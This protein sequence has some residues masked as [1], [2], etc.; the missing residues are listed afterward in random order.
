MFERS[1][2]RGLSDEALTSA[3]TAETQAEAAAAARRLALI[4]E[5]TA[6]WCDDEDDASALKLIDGWAHAKAQVGAACNLGPH[7]A[8]TQ[9]RIGV[10]LRERL[11]R[12]AAV[13]GTG[14][15]SAKVISAITWRTHLVTDP[16]ALASIDAGIAEN[17]HGFGM[18]SENALTAAVDFWVHKYDPLAV[19]RSKTAA[20]DRYIEFGDKDDPDGV[21]SFWGRMRTTDA[22]ITDARADELADGVCANDPRTKRERRVDAI[23]ALAAGADRLTCLCGDSSCA[24][25]G[26]DPRSGAVTIYVLTGQN[27]DAGEGAE[28]ATGP[29]PDGPAPSTP[30]DTRDEAAPEAEGPDEPAAEPGTEAPSRPPAAPAAQTPGP[31]AAGRPVHP[32]PPT[33]PTPERPPAAPAARS[34]PPGAGAGI[35]LDGAIIPAHLLTEL[36]NTGAKVRPLSNP[37]ELGSENRY[38]PSAKLSAYVRMTAMTCAFPGCGR[39]AHKADLDHLTPWPAGATHPGN[40]RPYCR[41][42]HLIKTLNTGWAPAAHA[43]GSTTWTA[44]TG[45]TYTTRPLASVLFPHNTIRT[46]IP[47][48]RHISLIDHDDREP[49]LPTRQRTRK[50]DREY[51]INAE[52][53]RNAL[54]IAL[55]GDPPF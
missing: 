6:R 43:D 12:T 24:G 11:P 3:I 51:R 47:R 34:T 2:L 50:Q 25:S 16:D 29:G 31:A 40:L 5:A 49:T 54:Q 20:K 38:R 39:P 7:G 13:F 35:S 33:T 41:E 8:N 10:A 4:A 37:A 45:H 15:I 26:K 42:H 36:I 18:L 9:M 17:A 23:A 55:D 44:P 28:P 21:V 46:A 48:T 22:K 14:A 52:R 32:G 19:I 27:P 30:E 53:A 1:A